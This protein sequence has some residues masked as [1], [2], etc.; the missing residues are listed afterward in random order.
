MMMIMAPAAMM[1]AVVVAVIAEQAVENSAGNAE[2][3][4]S[5]RRVSDGAERYGEQRDDQ[6]MT[7]NWPRRPRGRCF[8]IIRHPAL[9]LVSAQAKYTIWNAIRTGR[10][11]P[12]K[13]HCDLNSSL[14]YLIGTASEVRTDP[15]VTP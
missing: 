12:D 6:S 8:T 4:G 11:I 1:M 14:P 13:P 3:R 2:L 7:R 5:R 10:K 9:V 15:S